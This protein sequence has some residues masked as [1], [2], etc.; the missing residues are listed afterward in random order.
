MQRGREDGLDVMKTEDPGVIGVVDVAAQVP[1][2]L[3]GGETRSVVSFP[4]IAT[5][6]SINADSTISVDS[7]A[8]DGSEVG[9]GTTSVGSGA[10]SFGVPAD[11]NYRPQTCND[12]HGVDVGSGMAARGG[13]ADATSTTM[14]QEI[15]SAGSD[16]ALERVPPSM[17]SDGVDGS[18]AGANITSRADAQGG[19]PGEA[20]GG[21]D[22]AISVECAD[23]DDRSDHSS[24]MDAVDAL[25][26]NGYMDNFEDLYGGKEGDGDGL[27]PLEVDFAAGDISL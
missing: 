4:V 2:G 8:G 9:A 5:S 22:G 13:T 1:S 16:D 12:A 6:A 7:Q 19:L 10:I 21:G 26:D 27:M 11:E 23:G 14:S 17:K 25:M 24:L 20:L 18:N 3:W 15:P